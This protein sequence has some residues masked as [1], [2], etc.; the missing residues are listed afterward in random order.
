M[1]DKSY[2]LRTISRIGIY[3]QALT[4]GGDPIKLPIPIVSAPLQAKVVPNEEE[5]ELMDKTCK[6]E[7]IV[8]LTVTKGFKPELQLEFDEGLPEMDSLV[9]GR[10]MESKTNVAGKV[11]VEFQ[12]VPGQTTVAPRVTGQIGFE[13]TAQSAS[14]NS[15]LYYID[16]DTKLA[17]ELALVAV[18]ATPANDQISIDAALAI[19]YSPELADKAVIIRGWIPCTFSK[20]TVITSKVLNLLS[21][22]ALGVD[23]GG[24]A[25]HLSVANCARRP[26]GELGSD[27]K[28]VINM[29][30][31]PDPNDGNGL[32]YQM[33]Y[34]S[35]IV[36]C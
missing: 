1:S 7:E 32:G 21:V 34:L 5:Q 15:G 18:S 4:S 13:V 27:P 31:L 29:R 30:I 17:K 36:A 6:G 28:R 23:F 35:D 19:E 12:T 11:F 20:A 22:E 14:T 10:I 33:R 25:A 9:H 8:G 3:R 2:G 24:R 26:G 16:R